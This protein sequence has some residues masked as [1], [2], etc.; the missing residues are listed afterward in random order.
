MPPNLTESSHK[1]GEGAD[2]V[3]EEEEEEAQNNI[4]TQAEL[5]KSYAD[6]NSLYIN[7]CMNVYW[8]EYGG[9]RIG[10]MNLDIIRINQQK[11]KANH[12]QD[13]ECSDPEIEAIKNGRSYQWR[14]VGRYKDEFSPHQSMLVN[15][16]NENVY[17][18]GANGNK[19]SLLKYDGKTI[20][21]LA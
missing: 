2:F 11:M 5:F 1:T 8:F 10:K 20:K 18:L 15:N 7:Q 6:Q 19:N 14:A 17:I 4:V 21:A 3:D 9:R 12:Q 16:E 13:S